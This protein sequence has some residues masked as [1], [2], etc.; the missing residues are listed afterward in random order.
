MQESS[1]VPPDEELVF[2]VTTRGCI[3]IGIGILSDCPRI[4][5]EVI[6]L[7]GNL[8]QGLAVK[9]FG[10]QSEG[11]ELAEHFELPD[12]RRHCRSS[13]PSHDSE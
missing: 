12:T 13:V 10:N 1:P 4:K 6:V 11:L 2:T 7:V 8:V 5:E 9:S 3:G